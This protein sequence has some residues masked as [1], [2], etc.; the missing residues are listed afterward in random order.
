MV[1]QLVATFFPM[2]CKYC[3]ILLVATSLL[4]FS[5]NSY[6]QHQ[7][8]ADSLIKVYEHLPKQDTAILRVLASIANNQTDPARKIEYTN[9]L[10]EAARKH[11]SLKYL[12][13]AYLNEGQAYRLMGDFD[14]AIYSLFKALDYAERSNYTRGIAASNTALA[15]VYSIIGDHT[16]AVIYYKK[17]LDLITE[18][19]SSLLANVMLNL[20]DEYYMS[21]MYDSALACFEESKRIYELMG[22]D[23]SGLAYN[24][25]NIGLVKAEQ[26][27]LE[28]AEVNVRASI[29][30]LERLED[31]YGSAIFLT[32][33]SE[34]Y[35]HK[36]MLKEAKVFADSS[37]A[38]SKRYGLKAEIRDNSLRLADINA[39]NAD[40]ETAYKYHRQYVAIKDSISNDEIYNKIENLESAFE[41]AKKQNEVN[42]L[43]ARQRTQQIVVATVIVVALII[44][45]L[46]LVIFRYYRSKVR[47][48]K[49]LEEQKH[50]L[51]SLIETKDK[52]FSII[53]H[54]LRGPISSF[55]GVS[56]LIKFFVNSNDTQQLL[57]VA[58]DID[59]SVDGLS[60]LL[61]NLL[62]WAMQEQ[63]HVPNVPERLEVKSLCEEILKAF[64][65]MAQGKNI[66]LVS[67]VP[68]GVVVWADRNAT[69]TIIRNL[70]NNALKFTEPGGQVTIS[71]LS[72]VEKAEICIADTGIGISEDKL[73]LIFKP[74]DKKS[75]YGTSGEKGL[76]LGLQLVNEFVEMVGGSITVSSVVGS[77]SLFTVKL[78]LF[79]TEEEDIIPR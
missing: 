32:Y 35:Q 36:G 46:A 49:I 19:D 38:L 6:S 55:H 43:K 53:S 8:I 12:H 78:P 1:Y 28:S 25:G 5:F 31:H 14:V 26:G 59:K 75:T 30:M 72:G 65:N 4:C 48:S 58:D 64:N 40:Y 57:E 74:K 79:E 39:M 66:T 23:Q 17:A 52:F 77:G 21:S 15:D 42:L 16:N 60:S 45:I 3:H 68:D 51:E 73:N 9:L 11:E 41:L 7:A 44:S 24:Y 67:E 18:R 63:G 54:D 10:L 33:M 22:N 27:D 2:I 13:H 50:S 29:R 37:M 47:L 69:M 61:D 71:G 34:I 20:G 56:N 62:T 76:G 70:V